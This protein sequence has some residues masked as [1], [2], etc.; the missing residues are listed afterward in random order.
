MDFF[1]SPAKSPDPSSLQN[2]HPPKLKVPSLFGHE[3]P[4][5]IHN[6][7]TFLPNF[8][9]KK[10]FNELYGLLSMLICPIVI[11]LTKK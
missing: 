2:I 4:A 10:L 5:F 3:K 8:S 9:L 6:Y 11:S 1:I 7:I